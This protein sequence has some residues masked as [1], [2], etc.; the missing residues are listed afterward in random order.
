ME[1]RRAFVITTALVVWAI[2]DE[3]KFETQFEAAFEVAFETVRTVQVRTYL[4]THEHRVHVMQEDSQMLFT[5]AKRNY[6]C[7]F[8]SRDAVFRTKST[9]R[10]ELREQLFQ[11]L[12]RRHISEHFKASD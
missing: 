6:D 10:L 4:L 9:A 11:L 8:V 5:I 12:E 2:F 7:H 3:T 1:T